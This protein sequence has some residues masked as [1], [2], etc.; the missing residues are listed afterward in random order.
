MGDGFEL[1]PT[2]TQMLIDFY[3]SND[4]KPIKQFVY[5]H[6]IDGIEFQP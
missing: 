4:M 3:E 2:F 5:K 1:Q 6:C